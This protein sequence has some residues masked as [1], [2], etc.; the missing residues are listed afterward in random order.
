MDSSIGQAVFEQA[1]AFRGAVDVGSVIVTKMDGH[2]KGG[3]A[4]SAVAA[5]KSPVISIG[6][7][8]H[9]DDYERFEAQ[10]FVSRLLGMGDLGGLI[11]TM[12]EAGLDKQA[13]EL[14]KKMTSGIFTLRDMYSQ[15]Q[16][17]MNMGSLSNVMSMIPGLSENLIPKGK[18]KEGAARLKRFCCMMDSMTDD[19]LD[20]KKPIENARAVRIARGSGTTEE[21]VQ[22]LLT[23]HK[24][25]AKMI[26]KM[27][28]MGKGKGGPDLSQMQRNPAA[29]MK[30]MQSIMDPKMMQQM[31]GSENMMKMM[32]QMGCAVV[33]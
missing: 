29:M 6:T 2:A 16:N 5:T 26:G 13:P 22:Q 31:G 28:K 18:E 23:E 12:K 19:E 9:F 11:T 25:F 30:Q 15:F 33:N 8:E 21:E 27:G 4:L 3:G 20:A 1:A 10:G 17:I 24:R 7:G 32:K 14:L